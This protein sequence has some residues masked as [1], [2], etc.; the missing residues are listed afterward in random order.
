MFRVPSTANP[1]VGTHTY[2]HTY[3]HT[4]ARANAHTHTHATTHTHRQ[5]HTYAHIRTHAHSRAATHKYM[6]LG[7]CAFVCA[8]VC[9][10]TIT[11]M[12]KKCASHTY[13]ITYAHTG[14]RLECH[15]AC[16]AEKETSESADRKREAWGRGSKA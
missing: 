1:S 15:N 5:K 6:W 10:L 12:R 4:H 16:V 11:Y 3:T 13:T 2:K 8:Y 7:G 9:A 14:Q